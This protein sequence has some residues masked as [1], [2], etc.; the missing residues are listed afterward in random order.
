[1]LVPARWHDLRY[2]RSIRRHLLAWHYTSV[3][4][5][6]YQRRLAAAC[7]SALANFKDWSKLARGPIG[8]ILRHMESAEEM[9]LWLRAKAAIHRWPGYL[10]M[11]KAIVHGNISALR[12]ATQ[13]WHRRVVDSKA[14]PD[15]QREETPKSPSLQAAPRRLRPKVRSRSQS[16]LPV[17]TRPHSSRSPLRSETQPA[18]SRSADSSGRLSYTTSSFEYAA[19]SPP[20]PW[21]PSA[22]DWALL[23][24]QERVVTRSFVVTPRI[25]DWRVVRAVWAGWCTYVAER[26]RKRMAAHRADWSYGRRLQSKILKQ[27]AWTCPGLGVHRRASNPSQ[28]PRVDAHRARWLPSRS[29][30]PSND[31]RHGDVDID[32]TAEAGPLGPYTD[33]GYRIGHELQVYEALENARGSVD[34]EGAYSGTNAVRLREE[35]RRWKELMVFRQQ[36]AAFERDV[37][38][39][40]RLYGGSYASARVAKSPAASPGREARG[41]RLATGTATSMPNPNRNFFF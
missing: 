40:R 34:M 25:P 11:K 3:A 30:L 13:Q 15:E 17:W 9:Q 10:S 6:C 8:K 32:L 26:C 14:I 39:G 41:L 19:P 12:R 31:K 37:E 18:R 16:P 24:G 5:V 38:H 20:P 35:H 7:L 21:T 33:R 4:G 22:H 2:I 28:I 1:M 27:W 36:A 23:R 29:T